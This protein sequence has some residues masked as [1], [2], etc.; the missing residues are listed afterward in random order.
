MLD[1]CGTSG[2]GETPQERK[3]RGGTARPAESEHPGEEINHLSK[4]NNIYE[5][6]QIKKLILSSQNKPIL[7]QDGLDLHVIYQ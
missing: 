2:T 7:K 4:S 3:R 6:S 1:S 5:K